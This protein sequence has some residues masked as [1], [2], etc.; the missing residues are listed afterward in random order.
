VNG[1]GITN[2]GGLVVLEKLFKEC[3]EVGTENTF[4]FILTN[5]PLISSLVGRYQGCDGFEFRVLEIRSYIHRLYFENIGFKDIIRECDIDLIYNFTGSAQPYLDC[6]QLV[7]MHNLLFYSR[8][9]N[10]RYREKFEFILWIRQVLLKGFVFRFMLRRARYI[11]IQSKHV[12]ACLS[13]FI[14]LTNKHVFIKSDIGVDNS[15]IKAPKHYD[16]SEKIKF[17]YIVGPHFD[18]M[19]KNFFDFTR[20][21]LELIKLGFDFEIDIT[22]TEDQLATSSLWDNSLNSRTNFHGYLNDPQY[23]EGLFCDNTVLISTSII[24]TLGLHVIEAIKNGILTIT[25]KEYYANEVYG[26]DR[27]CY[28]LFSNNSLSNT[29]MNIINDEDI[30][31]DKILAQQ[32]YLRENE[33]SKFNNVVDVFAEVLNV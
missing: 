22:L 5:S 10:K 32:R 18:Y 26:I 2:S 30:I 17:I 28:E 24:E 20:G 7:K 12:E 14:N 6:L 9:L 33:M 8:R 3:I 29:V 27:Y 13:D 19:H 31:T 23:V 11:E 25:P 15:S 4:V 21:M 1:I 16:F